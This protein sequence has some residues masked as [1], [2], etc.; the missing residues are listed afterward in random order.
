MSNLR[1]RMTAIGLGASLMYLFDP[2]HGSRRRAQLREQVDDLKH[3]V[4]DVAQNARSFSHRA[5]GLILE[6]RQTVSGQRNWR[7][8]VS[9][10]SV[11]RMRPVTRGSL[12]FLGGGLILLSSATRHGR[13]ASVRRWIGLGLLASGLME[14]RP[15]HRELS[16]MS[17]SSDVGR[18]PSTGNGDFERA[19]AVDCAQVSYDD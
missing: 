7:D 6:T 10:A 16:H 9:L 17:A 5:G 3:A 13:A 1:S 11:R 8:A 12:A 4:S 19:M 18:S 14:A 2:E 15:Q